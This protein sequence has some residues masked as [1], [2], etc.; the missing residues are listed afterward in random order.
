MH[1]SRRAGH[2]WWDVQ[3]T[4]AQ[5]T[6]PSSPRLAAVLL[7][8]RCTRRSTELAPI[9]ISRAGGVT[10]CG[11]VGWLT[12]RGI[13]GSEA[14][15]GVAGIDTADA[16]LGATTADRPPLITLD[17]PSPT[18]ETVVKM[19]ARVPDGGGV[20]EA[21]STDHP[22]VFRRPLPRDGR[23]LVNRRSAAEGLVSLRLC[24]AFSDIAVMSET[25]AGTYSAGWGHRRQNLLGVGGWLSQRAAAINRLLK[26][27]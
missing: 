20:E 18:R 16:C 9:S 27:T 21:S 13:C 6:R 22:V 4:S 10:G 8:I 19:S 7:R 12:R 2:V 11:Q 17:V 5:R 14:A 3:E 23:P 15:I 25:A 1:T 26:H 24:L